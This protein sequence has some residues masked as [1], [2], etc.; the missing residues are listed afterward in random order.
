MITQSAVT[1]PPAAV[2]RHLAPSASTSVTGESV[3]TCAPSAIA[4][5]ARPRT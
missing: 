5:P 2:T 4:A 1:A 3:N